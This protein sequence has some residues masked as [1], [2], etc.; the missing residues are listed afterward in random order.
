ME[1]PL[2]TSVSISF[3]EFLCSSGAHV[4]RLKL[5]YRVDPMASKG[6][7]P[8]WIFIAAASQAFAGSSE[9]EDATIEI[10]DIIV[11]VS[12]LIDQ[13]SPPHDA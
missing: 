8:T 12:S 10:E 13:A 5:Y 11:I 6:R 1:E 2:Q 7:C 4:F 9:I 3:L